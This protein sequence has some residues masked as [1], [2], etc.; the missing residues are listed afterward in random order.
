MAKTKKITGVPKTFD[1]QLEGFVGFLKANKIS[2]M[3]IDVKTFE[4]DLKQQRAQR[5]ADLE[6]ERTYKTLH[7][8]FMEDQSSRYNRY[9]TALSVLRA[10]HRDNASLLKGLAQFKRPRSGKTAAK[11][12][13]AAPKKPPKSK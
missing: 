3:G 13:A 8:S 4:A 5:Q 9:V 2:G 6:A 11:P 12:T 7:R 10:A 1:D